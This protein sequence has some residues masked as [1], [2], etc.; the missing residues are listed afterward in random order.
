MSQDEGLAVDPGGTAVS[1]PVVLMPGP[2][3]DVVLTGCE[4]R[5]EVLRLWEA[6]DAD[7]LLAERG[8]EVRGVAT[9]GHLRTGPELMRHLPNLEIIANQGVGYDSVDVAE[10]TRR[11]VVVTNTPSVLDDEVADTAMG[12]LLMTVRE[13]SAAERYLRAGR[14]E[15]EGPYPLTRATVTGRRL[16]ILGLGRIGEAIARRAE[17]FG[18]T[19]G[20][21]NRR[22][23]DVPYHY[24]PSVLEMA[25]DVDTL[26]VVIPGGESTRNLVDADVLKALGP[27]GV[28]VNVARGTVVD[29]PALVAALQDGTIMGAGLDVFADEPRVPAELLTMEHVV[30]LPHVGSASVP[31]RDAMS[32]LVVDNLTSWFDSG[33]ALTPVPPE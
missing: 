22:Q 28:L 17:A 12:L 15:A 1:R 11:G 32:R 19:V 23:K 18:M 6:A 31:T 13:L 24:Y 30:L 14:W 33:R 20:Y 2:M 26:V 7:A 25:A 27:D 5:F 3:S 16:G 21:H 4:S 10:A 9:G 29:E 8:A